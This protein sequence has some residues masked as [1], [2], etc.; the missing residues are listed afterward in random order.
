MSTYKAAVY[1]HI[2][3]FNGSI[4]NMHIQDMVVEFAR[5]N[6]HQLLEE[7][8]KAVSSFF[9]NSHVCFH[10]I[11]L[12]ADHCVNSGQSKCLYMCVHA[13]THIASS[14]CTLNV[15]FLHVIDWFQG[16]VQE[17]RRAKGDEVK[18]GRSRE[19]TPREEKRAR[20]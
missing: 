10:M 7:T 11:Y 13:E 14:Q 9:S 20:G 8:E 18:V 4:T 1:V 3:F 12:I 19:E 6:M 5:M 2:I 16:D 17:S 15:S